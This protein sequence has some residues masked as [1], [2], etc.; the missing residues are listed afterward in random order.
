VRRCSGQPVADTACLAEPTTLINGYCQA[1]LLNARRQNGPEKRHR[2]ART[3]FAID[4]RSIV[5]VDGRH[6]VTFQRD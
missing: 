6:R 2:L 3:P 1:V 4:Q 5:G